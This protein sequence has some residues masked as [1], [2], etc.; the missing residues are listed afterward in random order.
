MIALTCED[1]ATTPNRPGWV[2][3]FFTLLSRR[4]TQAVVD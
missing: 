2:H 4:T 1:M 3:P